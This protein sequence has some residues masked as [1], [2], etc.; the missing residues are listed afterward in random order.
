MLIL[1]QE[2]IH[3]LQALLEAA[4]K[5]AVLGHT[6]PDGDAL[7]STAALCLYLKEKLGKESPGCMSV[8]S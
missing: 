2:K 4:S 8:M 6:H 1:S 7:G 3:S 5:V